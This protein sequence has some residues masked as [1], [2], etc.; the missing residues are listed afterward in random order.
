LEPHTGVKHD[1]YDG[2]LDAWFPIILRS[3]GSGTYAEGFAGPG[4]YT[5][6]E[7]GSPVRALH[8]L[9]EMRRRLPELRDRPA[10]FVLVEKRRDRVEELIARFR[11]ELNDPMPGGE[12]RDPT[13]HVVIRRGTCEQTLH[14]GY[15]AQVLDDGRITGTHTRPQELPAARPHPAGIQPVV[16]SGKA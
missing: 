8:R 11:D 16:R 1:I 6:G 15:P 9:R 10:R 7:H 2:Y 3:F 12:Y 5:G 13:L 4:V 14:E